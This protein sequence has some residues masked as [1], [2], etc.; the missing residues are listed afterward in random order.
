MEEEEEI[1]MHQYPDPDYAAYITKYPWAGEDNGHISV[2]LQS[3]LVVYQ[4]GNRGTAEDP[5]GLALE[6]KADI[7]DLRHS[8]HLQHAGIDS[9]Y[10]ASENGT[11]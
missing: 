10:Q 11:S 8:E 3:S 9:D 7:D 6:T 2:E 1:Q 4:D 5:R